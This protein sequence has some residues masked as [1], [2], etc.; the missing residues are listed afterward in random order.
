[1]AGMAYITPLVMEV[2]TDGDKAQ[3]LMK[4]EILIHGDHCSTGITIYVSQN[5]NLMPDPGHGPLLILPN[6]PHSNHSL[7]VLGHLA[8]KHRQAQSLL[9]PSPCPSSR[10]CQL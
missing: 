7:Q 4:I 10:R 5:I 1:M 2:D 6:H 9:R 8:H 3:K